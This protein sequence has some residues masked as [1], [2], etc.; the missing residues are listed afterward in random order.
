[1]TVKFLASFH[2]YRKTDLTRITHTAKSG[3]MLFGDSGAFSAASQGAHVS[4]ADYEAWL[5]EWRNELTVYSNLDVIGDPV[6]TMRNQRTLESFGHK[7]LPV[8][9][10]GAPF[11]VLEELCEEYPYIALGGMV[12]Y[13]TSKLGHWLVKCFRIAAKHDARFHGFGQTRHEYLRD[14]PWYS[15]DSSSWGAGHRFGQLNLWDA[16][17]CKFVDVGI[18]DTLAVRRNSALIR[19]HGVDPESITNRATYHYRHAIAVNAVGWARYEAFLRKRHGGVALRDNSGPVGPHLYLAEGAVDNIN[20]ATVAI[21][22]YQRS[23]A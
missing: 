15:I 20:H 10:V 6:A 16:S 11:A 8:F 9:H 4:V 14:F 2:Y 5:R 19:E 23:K 13:S 3:M 1:M 18:R 7:P 17:A 21:E 22:R 12:P